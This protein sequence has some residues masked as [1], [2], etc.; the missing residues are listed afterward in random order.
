M[1]RKFSMALVL[2]SV[3]FFSAGGL[4]FAGGGG[5]EDPGGCSG[6][7]PQ[8]AGGPQLKGSFTVA[9]CGCTLE[10]HL[11]NVHVTLEHGGATRLFSFT[12]TNV[13]DLCGVTAEALREKFKW[14]PCRLGAAGAFGLAGVPVI[15]ELEITGRADCGTA[16]AMLRGEVAVRVAPAVGK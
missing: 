13:E 10:G 9:P 12:A 7:P 8:P 16:K 5:P 11:L 3:V 2:A 14:A 15:D 4:A 1:Q 6:E